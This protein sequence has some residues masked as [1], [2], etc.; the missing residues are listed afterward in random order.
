MSNKYHA[1]IKQIPYLHRIC[2][3]WR[4]LS[5]YLLR[6]HSMQSILW[7]QTNVNKNKYKT[8][9]MEVQ[10][11]FMAKVYFWFDSCQQGQYNSN[12]SSSYNFTRKKHNAP[13][14]GFKWQKMIKAQFINS[15]WHW[16]Q[17][18]N[19]KGGKWGPK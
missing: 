8:N 1:N 18:F 7:M 14:S 3:I 10:I 17:V 9:I 12:H 6:A 4:R 13:G 11:D 19:W 5:F 2:R 15:W 16:L